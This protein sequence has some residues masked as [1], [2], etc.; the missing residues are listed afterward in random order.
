[1]FDRC[2]TKRFAIAMLTLGICFPTF[3]FMGMPP[4]PA[5]TLLSTFLKHQKALPDDEIRRLSTIAKQPGGTKAVNAELGR[6]HLPTEVL[7]DT[8]VRILINQ[9]TLSRQEAEGIFFRL[10]GTPG[11]PSTLSK[12]IG[13]SDVKASGHL[14]ELRIADAA[15]Q[16][17]FKVGGIGIRFDDGIKHGET[18]IDVLLLIGQR[19]I[20]IEA[21]DYL[22]T[23]NIVID[24]FRSDF[25]SL[26]QYSNQQPPPK[27]ITVFSMTNRSN[28]ELAMQ[29]IQKE[30]KRHGVELIFGSPEQQIIQIKQLTE[31][32]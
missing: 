1:M 11:M 29:I 20:A 7:E 14:N 6:L 32:L 31:I 23:T 28:D 3:A 17:G 22:P 27:P 10:R 16:H 24:K 30:A 9:S 4:K 26:A 25:V 15:S 13:A 2:I 18:D 8:Y 21:K 12:M 5:V 19:K